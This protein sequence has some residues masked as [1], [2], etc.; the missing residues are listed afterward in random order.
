M[1]R[2]G[3]FGGSRIA[4]IDAEIDDEALKEIAAVTGGEYF[5]A[6]DS[7]ALSVIYEK[8]DQLERSEIEELV[9]VRY[10]EE[11]HAYV[12]WALFLLLLEIVLLNTR[13]RRL[14]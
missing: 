1:L 6:E 4:Y 11:F 5:R 12:G 8:I 10:T 7:E 13:F 9:N 3:I 14:A 2:P